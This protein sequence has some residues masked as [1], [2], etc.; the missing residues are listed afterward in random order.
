MKR[1]ITLFVA[2]CLVVGGAVEALAQSGFAQKTRYVYLWDVTGSIINK[3]NRA[4]GLYDRMYGYIN[5]DV[6]KK[7]DGTEIIVVPFNDKV[8]DV[9]K[10]EVRGNKI[11]AKD[12]VEFEGLS[13]YGGKKI[14]EHLDAFNKNKSEKNP[15]VGGFTDIAKSLDSVKAEYVSD[16]YNTI[17]ILLTD[18]GQEYIADDAIG[19]KGDEARKWL[20]TAIERFDAELNRAN[21]FNMLYYVV[22]DAS[23]KFSPHNH[24]DEMNLNGKT[25]F[26]DATE[27]SI[28]LY[29]CPVSPKLTAKNNTISCRDNSYTVRLEADGADMPKGVELVVNDGR[30]SQNVKLDGELAEV[31]CKDRY[32]LMGGEDEE[33]DLTLS[34]KL[35]N[36]GVVQRG[37]DIFVY[38]LNDNR[39]KLKV[40]NNF[41]PTITVRLKK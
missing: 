28:N 16:D 41:R 21:S 13:A 29:F 20:Q 22:T 39:L 24:R 34:V 10:Y 35:P 9:I 33:Y 3:K 18:G 23:D 36:D 31:Q 25:A 30:G 8:I 2:M 32:A 12:G 7:A 11:V 5:D 4:A 37:D 38:W 1:L 17:F 27:G 40:T 26:I 15:S 14:Q 6:K 19:E